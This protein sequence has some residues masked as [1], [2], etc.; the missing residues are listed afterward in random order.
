MLKRIKSVGFYLVG[1]KDFNV[2]PTAGTAANRMLVVC[3]FYLFHL[4]CLNLSQSNK[5]LQHLMQID[6]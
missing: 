3:S 4:Y 2:I 5:V 6:C 1:L